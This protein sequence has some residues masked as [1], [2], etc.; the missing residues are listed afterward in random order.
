MMRS[1]LLMLLLALTLAAPALAPA[2][3]QTTSEPGTGSAAEVTAAVRLPAITVAVVTQRRMQDRI[4]ASGLVA[5]VE[6]IAVAP[7]VEGQ[8]IEALMADVGDRVSAGQVLARLSPMTLDLQKSQLL[9]SQAAAAATIAQAEAQVT[10]ATAAATEAD[11]VA[12][13]AEALAKQ[14]S[15]STAARDQALSAAITATAQVTVAT[16]S[17]EA[18]RAQARLVVAQIANLDLQLS[19]TEVVAPFAGEIT[20]R[21]AMLGGIAS[22]AGQPMFILIRDGSLELR[23]DVAEV[24]MLRIAVGQ[25]AELTVSGAA[26][27]LSGFVRLVE[28]TIDAATR[29]GR[30]RIKIAGSSP[31][32]P[33]MFVSA[34]IMVADRETLVVPVTALAAAEGVSTVMKVSDG[35]VS[36][37]QVE[38]GIRQGGFVEIRS[39]LA[40]GDLVV[41]KAAAFV[42]D[43]D[44][45]NPILAAG[46]TN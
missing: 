46:Q 18:A 10:A 22:A 36:L 24:D 41:A 40:P 13:R 37:T 3:A 28:P 4:S 21:N 33:G 7:L 39:G 2:L 27:R 43:G 30:A 8:P 45:I 38:T 19:R 17:L 15:M 5:P 9:A 25:S 1:P 34:E 31:L 29:L 6:E 16:Q 23:A 32:R 14:G 42:R 44:I 26:V 20:A 35:H 11:R 12:T